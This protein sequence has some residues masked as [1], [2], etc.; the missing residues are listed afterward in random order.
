MLNDINNQI[1][2]ILKNIDE[3]RDDEII[4]KN[5]KNLK[6]SADFQK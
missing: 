5:I 6:D 4:G 2:A 1:N 3:E